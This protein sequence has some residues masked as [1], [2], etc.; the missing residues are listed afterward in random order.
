MANWYSIPPEIRNIILDQVFQTGAACRNLGACAAVCREWQTYIE[1]RNFRR[2]VLNHSCV[3]D[4]G[5]IVQKRKWMVQHIWLRIELPRYRCTTCR[6]PETP[7]QKRRNNQIFTK[8]LFQLLQILGSWQ[9]DSMSR[10]GLEDNIGPV[11]ELSV[12]SPSDM[13]H[14]FDVFALDKDVYPH[15]LD[16][17]CTSQEFDDYAKRKL[18]KDFDR[19]QV[20]KAAVG[21]MTDIEHLRMF[22]EIKLDL[23]SMGSLFLPSVNCIK[24][25]IVRRQYYRSFNPGTVA[26]IARSF[27]T[28]GSLVFEPI[29]RD[30]NPFNRAFEHGYKMLILETYRVRSLS[31]FQGFYGGLV[32]RQPWRK[33]PSEFGLMLAD[34]SAYKENLSVAFAV[35]A[36]AFFQDFLQPG[37]RK[38]R[39]HLDP[40]RP[41]VECALMGRLSIPELQRISV[42]K[43]VEDLQGKFQ[44]EL[45]KATG[46]EDGQIPRSVY[47]PR[48]LWLKTLALTSRFRDRFDLFE[49]AAFAALRMPELQIMEIWDGMG[50][51]LVEFF[52]YTRRENRR[53]EPPTITWLSDL[54]IAPE[55]R[56]IAA[57]ERVARMHTR[58]DQGIRVLIP[59][60]PD[61]DEKPTYPYG[62]ISYLELRE[63]IV[64]QLSLREFEWYYDDWTRPVERRGVEDVREFN[65]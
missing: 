11:L 37:S 6:L 22:A 47:Q 58:T 27:G 9:G 35:D 21:N 45:L 50:L 61:D 17:K 25:L 55:Q 18:W 43:W 57:W 46:F 33:L 10:L 31:I 52:R 3:A 26:E 63:K 32:L 59:E 12:H 44:Q 36:I 39:P 4:F 23:D 16:E 8:A 30:P 54:Q 24:A 60:F 51:D 15:K 20:C 19:G 38:Y 62:T 42:I 56:V 64:H 65:P 29:T 2:L 49:A 41:A 28:I 13:K 5:R 7:K 34:K 40:S 1:P 48:W 14:R 53:D